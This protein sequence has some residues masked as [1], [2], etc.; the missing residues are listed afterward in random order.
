MKKIIVAL[1]FIISLISARAQHYTPIHNAQAIDWVKGVKVLGMP[2]D[3]L[4]TAA[5]DSGAIA[6]KNGVMYLWNG[7]KWI[8]AS[9]GG[10]AQLPN[11]GS[12]YRILLPGNGY[13]TLY[14]SFG[15]NFDTTLHTGGITPVID[16]A[17]LATL[18]TATHQDLQ[19]VTANGNSTNIGMVVDNST[20]IIDLNRGGDG[21]AFISVATSD[22]S[23][24][25]QILPDAIEFNNAPSFT[26]FV[27]KNTSGNFSDTLPGHSGVIAL[28]AA[29]STGSP[30]NILYQD[31]NGLL[32]KAAVPGGTTAN[33]L[34]IPAGISATGSSTT[35]DGS[36]ARTLTDATT[37]ATASKIALRDGNANTNIN[38]ALLGYQTVASGVASLTAGSPY[39]TYFTNSSPAGAAL[40]TASTSIALGQSYLIVAG[41][42]STV[43][44][45][46]A[47]ANVYAV[48]ASGQRCVI[49]C[50]AN[51]GGTTSASWKIGYSSN[52]A[53]VTVTPAALTKTDDTNITLI[54]GGTPATALLQAASITAGWTGTLANSRGGTGTG[55]YATGDLLYASATNTLS[56]LPIGTPKQTLHIVGGVPV[57]R[58]TVATPTV[59]NFANT[60]LTQTADRSYNG[61]SHSLSMFGFHNFDINTNTLGDAFTIDN[62]GAIRIGNIENTL[63]GLTQ[64]IDA[65]NNNYFVTNNTFADGL[66]YLGGATGAWAI[67]DYNNAVGG[68]GSISML[69][70]NTATEYNNQSGHNFTGDVKVTGYSDNQG[71]SFQAITPSL[72]SYMHFGYYSL[73]DGDNGMLNVHLSGGGFLAHGGLD[74]TGNPEEGWNWSIGDGTNTTSIAMTTGTMN[75]TSQSINIGGLDNTYIL[76][77]DLE[78]QD[79]NGNRGLL[80]GGVGTNFYGL[81]DLSGANEGTA[82]TINDNT[83]EFTVS[84][85]TSNIYGSLAVNSTSAGFLPPRMTAVQRLAIVLPATGL[86]VY[87]TDGTEGWY[88]QKSTGWVLIK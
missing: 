39:A 55:T 77:N 6:M 52:A 74:L 25:I 60:D 76:S 40:P 27:A 9:G 54:L 58:D 4:V 53:P 88:G 47:D 30:Q 17:A 57:W 84:A 81:G 3:T 37:A 12:G 23:K 73:G 36:A 62:A 49:T 56:K 70:A 13:K 15:I 86:M 78:V 28:R 43:S 18:Y 71:E 22:A 11:I 44:I 42:T 34:T 32:H 14:S 65:S 61:A 38:N 80:V 35:F 59:Q 83:S 45:S 5:S 33:A 51:A 69:A 64:V 41:G 31:N 2:T 1:T 10:A 48:L 24:L 29:D 21:N 50:V 87:Q 68:L 67:G 26:N 46:T 85:T 7:V 82:I 20:G 63:T 66:L 75:L 79:G 8:E 19:A 72:S 16:T